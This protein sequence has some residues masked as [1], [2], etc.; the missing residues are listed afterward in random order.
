MALQIE[1]LHD[2]VFICDGYVR[3]HL[4]SHRAKLKWNEHDAPACA[5][6]THE[7]RFAHSMTLY[8][9]LRPCGCVRVLW[10]LGALLERSSRP[11]E[12]RP[13]LH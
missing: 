7:P 5:V 10:P 12:R 8:E 1:E 4:P 6:A 2:H 9:V 11:G 13:A 3:P